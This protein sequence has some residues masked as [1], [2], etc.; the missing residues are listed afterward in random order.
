MIKFQ[1]LRR[2]LILGL[3]L[4]T[5]A[6]VFGQTLDIRGTVLDE[7]GLSIP[8]AT[9]LVKDVEGKGTLTDLEGNFVL[10]GVPSQG[11]LRISYVGMVT[12]ELPINGQTTF[13][14]TLREDSE[15]LDE[16]V[17]TALGMKRSTKALGYAV[18]ELK[19]DDLAAT[20]TINPVA[21]LQGKVAGVDIKGTDGGLFGGSKIQ[22]RGA[23]TLGSNNQ[24][25]YVVDGVILDNNVSGSDDL[26]WTA[27]SNDY[28]NMLKN[29]NPDDFESVS[30]LK[31]AAATA[32]YGS[33]GLNGAVVITTKGGTKRPGIGITFSQTFG[34]DHV[35]AT[36][37]RQMLYGPG[38]WP[39][40]NSKHPSGNRFRP[41]ELVKNQD[42][43]PS[44]IQSSSVLFGPRI[45]PIQVEHYDKSLQ[46]W[47]AQPNGFRDMYQ[48][49]LNSNTNLSFQGGDAKSNFYTSLSYRTA[50][51]TTL[52][53]NFDR[54][55]VFVK[56]FQQLTD[57]WK[58]STSINWTRSN[59]ANAP[60]N[61]GEYFIQTALPNDY[62]PNYND[63]KSK[64][65]AEHGGVA[66]SK[67][68]D[69]NGYIPG[70][71]I[72]FSLNNNDYT[73]VEDVLRPTLDLDFKLAPWATLTLS[74][75]MNVYNVKSEGKYLGGGYAREGG[76]YS[77]SHSKQNQ[78][79]LSSTL[80]MNNTWDKLY[81]GGFVRGEVYYQDN[82]YTSLST[83]GGLIV[84]GQY[85]IGNSK[86]TPDYNGGV[87]NT[88]QINSLIGSLSIS[89]DDTYFLDITG[90][91]DWSS[92]LVYSN[93]TGMYSYFYP[94]VSGSW[95]FTNTIGRTD[96][97]TFGKLRA[98]WA[99][100]GNDTAP[101]FINNAYT[102]GRIERPDGF[103]YTN[104]TPNRLFDPQIRPERKNAF[105]IG[106]DLRFLDSRIQLDLTYYRENTRDQIMEITIPW[107]SGSTRQLI[108]AGNIQNE[109]VE[110]ALNTVP[111]RTKDWEWTLDM[112]YTKNENKIIEL[113]PNVTSYI[114][115]QGQP[116]NYDYRVGSVAIAGGK[117]GV[118]MSD[119][120]P[121]VNENGD[122]V[123]KWSDYGRGAYYA[124]SGKVE[125]VGDINP[126]FLASLRSSLSWK[127]IRL[128]IA[129]DARFGGMVASYANRY[130]TA[131]GVTQTSLRYRDAEHGG[132]SWT[133]KYNLKDKASNSNGFE[134]HDG[135]IPE[136]VFDEGVQATLTTGER[137]DVSGQRY[138][139]LV[140][141]GLLEPTHAGSFH[142]FSNSWGQGTLNDDWFHELSYIALR[143]ISVSYQFD[144]H[145]AEALSATSLGIGFTA[146][147]LGYLYNS[148]PNNLHPE[149]VRGN[150]AG[151][152]RIR[153]FQPYTANYMLT[154]NASF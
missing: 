98:S 11:T 104:T 61:F 107:E 30:V 64:Y 136:G 63:F 56:G 126:D 80:N 89:Y 71:G 101:Y 132:I 47:Q 103:I 44:L 121:K 41:A 117:Y 27:N 114:E 109:G 25:I 152:F 112:T 108:N 79:T 15:M 88:K 116:N 81:V 83:K 50:R 123:L 13:N 62:S 22:I 16:V 46:T 67:Y 53:N 120:K 94:S 111:I 42:G 37:E 151:E 1:L 76:S 78:Y 115:L 7:N 2:G 9:V 14:I 87:N 6:P 139:D 60:M 150:R 133:S 102:I 57:W 33:R 146:R 58:L 154:I 110:I 122:K 138:S 5:F 48:L 119:I 26:N 73:Q 92:A 59:A 95:I 52:N 75:N 68:G 24:P 106:T 69:A 77:I 143:E 39:G 51:G 145:I 97:F 118:L 131:Y 137:V 93:A 134:Y 38:F 149:S 127:N 28:G 74:G 144:K 130:G 31:G 20:N 8:G 86:E 148:L 17:V 54:F 40:Q 153:A 99:Q 100:V 129:L 91:N 72:W 90:R 21:S 140:A 12:Q 105:E 34:L 96:W 49:G 35:F 82:S 55:S 18:T 43:V 70:N 125:E 85:F 142:Y 128:S 66:D 10:K 135:V 65:Q 113:H 4:L 19:G 141:K 124:R 23:S 147:N 32:L 36:P 45:E 3:L 84:P 29:L